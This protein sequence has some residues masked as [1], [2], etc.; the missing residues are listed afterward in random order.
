MNEL[1]TGQ[2]VE[3]YT[4]GKVEIGRVLDVR[5]YWDD[6][7]DVGGSEVTLRL[8][9]REVTLDMRRIF[10]GRIQE[11]DIPESLKG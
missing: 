11:W 3:C 6:A 4:G 10:R 9:G 2:F 1:R 7:N 8:E 5:D